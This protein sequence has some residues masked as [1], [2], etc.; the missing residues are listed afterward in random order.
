MDGLTYNW[1][2]RLPYLELSWGT[3]WVTNDAL[4]REHVITISFLI[5]A[6]PVLKKIS[7]ELFFQLG[8]ELLSSS[9]HQSFAGHL[10]QTLKRVAF[11][12][13]IRKCL[14]YNKL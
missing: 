6:A 4:F 7:P 9:L 13:S 10:N 2:G 1:K 3:F 11:G 12:G 5:K 8:I 14:R